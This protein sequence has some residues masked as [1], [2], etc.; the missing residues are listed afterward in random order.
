MVG[1]EARVTGLYS[2]GRWEALLGKKGVM[3]A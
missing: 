2:L 1:G 3:S